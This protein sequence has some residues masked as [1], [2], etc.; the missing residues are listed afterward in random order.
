MSRPLLSAWKG[1]AGF[2]AITFAFS[3]VFY[4]LI[5]RMGQLAAGQGLYVAGI[6]WCPG[7]A[8]IL[9]CRW[10]KRDVAELGWQWKPNY[11]FLSY[12][13]PLCY[14]FGAY[15]AVWLFGFGG[16]P[17]ER[18]VQEMAAAFGWEGL[19]AGLVIALYVLVLGTVGMVRST[20]TALGEEI[21]WRG[22]LVPELAKLTSFTTAALV[23]GITWAV[24]H[25]PGILY[26]DYNSGTPAWYGLACFTVMVVGISFPFA[27]LRLKSGSLWTGAFLHGSHN[28]FIQ[29]VFT[30]L[31]LDTGITEYVIDEFGAA[32]A[33]VALIVAF[34]FWRRRAE[35]EGRQPW[36]TAE[37][38]SGSER[39]SE[40]AA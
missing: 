27:W 16:F 40:T 12:V 1:I 10:L 26:A 15:L 14:A 32:L 20:A 4:F 25:Y 37:P 29:G 31:T 18:F 8:A 17:N 36:S 6:M 9:T 19:P 23:S 33:G 5:L 21:G 7:I 11:Q 30:P 39:S 34:Y 35:V 22:F 3:S 28:L 24:W 38:T 13:I 2:L